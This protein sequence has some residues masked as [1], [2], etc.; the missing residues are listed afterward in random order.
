MPGP[1][2]LM[3]SHSA[4]YAAMNQRNLNQQKQVVK[5]YT[6]RDEYL[7][8]KNGQNGNIATGFRY[9]G[10]NYRFTDFDQDGYLKANDAYFKSGDYVDMSDY[11][12]DYDKAR[13][14]AYNLG[15]KNFSYGGKKYNFKTPKQIEQPVTQL[16]EIIETPTN[17][18]VNGN[19]STKSS[20]TVTPP[21]TFTAY[22]KK[23]DTAEARRRQEMMKTAGM[24]L[25][26][27]GVDGKWGA[28]SKAR[29]Q[30]YL[31]TDADQA[32][33]LYHNDAGAAEQLTNGQ[34]LDLTEQQLSYLNS[35]D[36]ARYDKVKAANDA[37]T[38]VLGNWRSKGGDNINNY[39][40]YLK[41]VNTQNA[42][43]KD[44]NQ[45]SQQNALLAD[46]KRYRENYL[47]SARTNRQSD[48]FRNLSAMYSNP[49]FDMSSLSGRELRDMSRMIRR[50][51]RRRRVMNNTADRTA[52]YRAAN[53]D[54]AVLQNYITADPEVKAVDM[55]ATSFKRGGLISYLQ[56]LNK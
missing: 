17:L 1:Y 9:N 13:L 23:F 37:Y 21:K 26:P 22:D 36:K 15:L 39:Q 31:K 33:D 16:P 32:W 27:G 10:K 51:R 34:L 14:Y 5:P 8:V 29:W 50:D 47:T 35:A 18:P 53:S 48:A 28:V 44:A 41:W 54:A 12:S 19:Q 2:G 42:Q 4:S 40:D 56:Y 24:D 43:I 20:Q 3:R 52:Y 25:G 46:Q 7:K 11:F 38:T 30:D 55:N 45:Q 49:N 6:L